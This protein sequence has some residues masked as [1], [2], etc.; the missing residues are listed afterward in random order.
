MQRPSFYSTLL[1]YR[2][3]R[4]C[5]A[6]SRAQ[7]G[8]LPASNASPRLVADHTSTL[9]AA[10]RPESQGR[11]PAPRRTVLLFAGPRPSPASRGTSPAR[12]TGYSPPCAYANPRL[13]CLDKHRSITWNTYS[14]TYVKGG[15]PKLTGWHHASVARVERQARR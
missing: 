11:P 9:Q 7:T 10:Y 8:D 13:R 4:G 2:M 1:L 14:P 5:P 12:S 6:C 3:Y 15:A